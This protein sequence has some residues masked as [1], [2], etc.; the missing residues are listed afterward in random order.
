[1]KQLF[2]FVPKKNKVLVER[3]SKA[4]YT[5]SNND[6]KECITT[7][8]TANAAG[9]I[10]PSM[11]VFNYERIPSAIV[12]QMPDGFAFG[13]SESGWMT[14]ETFFEYID[15][16]FYPWLIKMKISK[17]CAQWE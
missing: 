17:L 15:N 3:G 6:E 8:I 2:F 10:A 12:K 11:V 5:Y 9:Q 13:T 16:V 1:M 14:G 4:V 7:L